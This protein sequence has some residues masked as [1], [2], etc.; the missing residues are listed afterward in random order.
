MT[1]NEVFDH[2]KR[3]K[4]ALEGLET[5]ALEPFNDLQVV[6]W[7]GALSDQTGRFINACLCDVAGHL[8]KEDFEPTSR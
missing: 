1:N 6:A 3:C 2:Y 7:A 8:A 4:N 5:A